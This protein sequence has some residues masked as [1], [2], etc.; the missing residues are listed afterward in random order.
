V[1]S[2]SESSSI[3][4]R[5]E[6]SALNRVKRKGKIEGVTERASMLWEHECPG[7]SSSLSR[8]KS[9][10]RPDHQRL[11]AGRG[12]GARGRV[13]H[14]RRREKVALNRDEGVPFSEETLLI[15]K[16]GVASKK[17]HFPEEHGHAESII[18]EKGGLGDVERGIDKV[19]QKRR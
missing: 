18:E 6:Q 13:R 1:W 12:F 16:E 17:I 9:W 8:A 11:G 15:S 14:S 10:D 4:R 19:G 2:K 7:E 5:I 3:S